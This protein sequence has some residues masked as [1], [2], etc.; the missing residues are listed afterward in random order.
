MLSCAL[1][2]LTHV[3]YFA[4]GIAVFSLNFQNTPKA[5]G[6]ELRLCSSLTWD[7]ADISRNRRDVYQRPDRGDLP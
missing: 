7:M 5:A 6:A 3:P 2:T 4:S 1:L